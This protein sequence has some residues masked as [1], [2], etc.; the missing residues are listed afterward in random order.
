VVWRM[1]TKSAMDAAGE[2]QNLFEEVL[3]DEA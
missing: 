3:K 2:I 1:N